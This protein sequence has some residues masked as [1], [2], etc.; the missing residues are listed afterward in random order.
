LSAVLEPVVLGV[1]RLGVV[2]EGVVVR[3][4]VGRVVVFG[5]VVFGFVVVEEPDFGDRTIRRVAFEP[6]AKTETDWPGFT[7]NSELD[8]PSR[9]TRTDLATRNCRVVFFVVDFTTSRPELA[10]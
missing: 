2:L 6:L 3:G 1:V 4:V 10:E 9:L 5:F 8:F 7:R